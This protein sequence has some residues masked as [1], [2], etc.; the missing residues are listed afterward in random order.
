MGDDDEL[1]PRFVNVLDALS[2]QNQFVDETANWIHDCVTKRVTINQWLDENENEWGILDSLCRSRPWATNSDTPFPY[3][4][5]EATQQ[6][7]AAGEALWL[8][9]TPESVAAEERPSRRGEA[10]NDVLMNVASTVEYPPQQRLLL[11]TPE[12]GAS[13]S[14]ASDAWAEMEPKGRVDIWTVTWQG[15]TDFD[16]MIVEVFRQVETFADGV[17]TVWF[18]H[19]MGAI[20]M[21]ECLQRMHRRQAPCLPVAVFASG[22]PA[23]HMFEEAYRPL[24]AHPWINGLRIKHDFEGLTHK[25]L[26]ALRKDFSVHLEREPS[27][28]DLA[29][30]L[31]AISLPP[32]SAAAGGLKDGTDLPKPSQA[33]RSAV[34]NDLR[35]MLSYRFKHQEDRTVLVPLVAVHSDEDELVT[36]E[37]VEA[38]A[39]YTTEKFEALALGEVE[40]GELLASMGHGFAK[41]PP[42]ALARKVEEISERYRINKDVDDPSMLPDV[43]PT[44][45]PLPEEC[46]VL[47]V[48]AGITGVCGARDFAKQGLDSL[49]LEK[50]DAVGGIWKYYANVYSRVNTSEVGYRIMDQEGPT[51]RPNQDHSPRHDIMR[52]IYTICA[53]YSYGKVR[54]GWEVVKTE[55]QEDDKWLVTA[56]NVQT[57]NFKRVRA[58]CVLMAVNRRIGK[59]RDIT[60]N[61][62]K[63]FRGDICYGYANELRHLNFWGKRVIVVG[64]GAFAFENLRTAIE[65]GAKFVT[66]L[67]RR[68]GTTCPKWIDMLAFIRP[69]DE[70]HM[71]HKAGNMISFQCWQKCYQDAGLDTPECWAQGIL[72][73]HGHT[74]SVSDLA[75]IAGYHGMAALKV[76][77]IKRFRT[78]GHGVE[79]MDGTSMDC[80]IVIKCTGF[81]LNEEVP[82]ITGRSHMYPN[83]LIDL[84]MAYIAE[85]LLD[86]GQFGSAKGMEDS[87]E[88]R[89]AG[90][91]ELLQQNSHKLAKLPPHIARCFMPRGNPFGSGYGG[92]L[93]A[94]GA[95]VAWLFK[96]EDKQRE[97][98]AAG[99]AR[100]DVVKYWSSHIPIGQV[101]ELK[102]VLAMACA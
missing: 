6:M 78:D 37:A 22:C 33:Q 27:E 99:K 52:D 40:D 47:I 72:K 51:A 56:R 48:G 5:R 98:L 92:A 24:D 74:I 59:R 45:G 4:F 58:R 79:L 11:F 96:N 1:N 36:E 49:I 15:W 50:T 20:V 34:M 102:S 28:A 17:S 95:Y 42:R 44:D 86:G 82:R 63:N 9:D 31:Y 77:E 68:A 57:N 67:G 87:A 55:K 64:A 43:G 3:P 97:V 88:I 26:E 66:I 18:G 21:Y 41:R 100:M 35:V 84:N 69:T 83:M 73:P 23:P 85:P 14:Y 13:S 25:E 19:S 91:D 54:C 62:E 2:K 30:A 70:N 61:D 81:H 80:D 75:F 16:N 94:Q 53:E 76:G 90:L 60:F 89:T 46:E 12:F 71:T 93:L 32:Y 8:G 10:P 7:R 29:K 39:G 101:E 65:H 38:W